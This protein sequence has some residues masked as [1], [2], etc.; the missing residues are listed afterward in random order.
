MTI[1]FTPEQYADEKTQLRM[2]EET[3]IFVQGGELHGT[4][5]TYSEIDAVEDF[6]APFVIGTEEYLI[7][8]CWMQVDAEGLPIAS[9]IDTLPPGTV[10]FRDPTEDSS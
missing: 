9:V 10:I 3:P 6:Y 4:H 2:M 7:M 5:A 1:E 8:T